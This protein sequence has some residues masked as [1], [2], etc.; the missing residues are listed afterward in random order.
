MLEGLDGHLLILYGDC[1]LLRVET[2]A[3]LIETERTSGA[4]GVLMTAMM[5]DPTGYGRVV[6][7]AH[8]RV[9]RIVEQKAGTPEELAIR[10]ANMGIYCFRADL[11]WKHAG[12]IGTDNPAGEYYL[13]AVKEDQVGDW[14]DPALLRAL[15]S[16]AMTIRLVDGERKTQDLTSATVR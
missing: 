2:L 11:F 9:A 16:L 3:R 8:G 6:R 15:S 13:I 4:A 12:E 1:P 7:D 14:Q 10:E 5:D